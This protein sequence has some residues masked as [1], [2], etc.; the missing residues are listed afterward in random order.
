[1]TEPVRAAR[2]ADLP[3]RYNAIEILERN[4]GAPER[5]A[6]VADGEEWT[7]GRVAEQVDRVSAALLDADVRHG[8]AV[9]I[10]CLDTSEW[11]A[12]FFGALKVGAVAVGMNTLATSTYVAHVLNDCRA[13]VLVIHQVLLDLYLAVRDQ[14]PHVEHVVV[15][16]SGGWDAEQAVGFDDWL[17]G[18]TGRSVRAA[19][20]HQDD[21]ATLNYSSGTTGTPKGIFHAHKDLPLTAELW[22]VRTL[23]LE[24]TDRTF[25]VAKLFFV[26]GLGGNLVFPWYVGASAVLYSGSPRHA[27]DV[28]A[29]IDRTR[30][31]VLFNAPTGYASALAVPD[32]TDRHDLSCL[33][34]CVSA[35]EALPA[36]L[37]HAWKDRT[38]LDILDGIGSTECFHIF[39]SN[40]PGDVRPG[41]SGTPVE[42]YELRIVDEAGQPVPRGDVGNLHVRGESSAL[43]YLHDAARS[44]T[45]FLGEWLNTGDKYVQDEDGYFWHAGRSDD[46][47]KVGGIWVSPVEVESALIGHAAVL[48]CAVVGR[49]DAS[50]LIKPHAFV[51]LTP[52][53][54]ASE[55]LAAELIDHCAREMAAYKRP[56]WVEF[57]DTLPKTATGKIQRY[58][59][60]RD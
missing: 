13:R 24:A 3:S 41:S 10:L 54:T 50:D 6:L 22:G 45:T 26:Y 5:V 9:A 20:T 11:V 21:F 44:R 2:A 30:P 23:G 36:P 28:L 47:L 58:R 19:D 56:R 39:L 1:M 34:Y 48:E 42:G 15:V 4:L 57:V 43:F 12:T 38:G 31:T 35:G 51:V 53:V 46:M 25:S 29:V 7:F 18:P 8:E 14:A 33:R 17:A 59:L 60:R 32:F 16:G 49:A 40:R 37:W 52:G 55:A 27:R